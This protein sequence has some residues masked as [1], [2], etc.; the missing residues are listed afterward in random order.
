[1]DGGDD[2]VFLSVFAEITVLG[3]S[4]VIPSVTTISPSRF[5]KTSSWASLIDLI[6]IGA[7][8]R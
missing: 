8:L 4:F 1:M 5:T 3:K 7:R 6:T 2:L